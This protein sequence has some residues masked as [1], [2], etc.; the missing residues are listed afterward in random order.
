MIADP[1]SSKSNR[2]S[3]ITAYM[4]EEMAESP[5]SPNSDS[6]RIKSNDF[7]DR[8]KDNSNVFS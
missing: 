6:T 4:R 8:E 2:Y 7:F 3:G 5:N 1:N